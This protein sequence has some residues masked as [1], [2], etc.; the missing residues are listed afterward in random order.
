MKIKSLLLNVLSVGMLFSGFL[1]LNTRIEQNVN[2]GIEEVGIEYNNHTG[3]KLADVKAAEI[4]G[5]EYS[6]TYAQY[7][8]DSEGKYY[9]R[10][11][12]AIKASSLDSIV[13][14]RAEMVGADETVYEAS[15]IEVTTVYSYLT[16]NGV[17]T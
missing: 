1:A 2:P 15:D 7:A 4:E 14:H 16:A 10:F 11:A 17:I 13:Y 6:N 8:K 12:T 3:I 9:V 5:V